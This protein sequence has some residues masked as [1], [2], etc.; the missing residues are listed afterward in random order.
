MRLQTCKAS[1][2]LETQLLGKEEMDSGEKQPLA[3]VR[4]VSLAKERNGTEKCRH[5]R[6]SYKKLELRWLQGPTLVPPGKSIPG[7]ATERA[8]PAC[9]EKE[10][11]ARKRKAR[12]QRWRQRGD[13]LTESQGSGQ[14]PLPAV[15][16]AQP[17][18][19][20][21]KASSSSRS[22]ERWSIEHLIQG[23]K[24]CRVLQRP[25]EPLPWAPD[26]GLIQEFLHG[27]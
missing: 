27:P 3:V 8:S 22:G 11:K 23:G 20:P 18:K 21:S 10:R 1:L 24:D 4:D 6:R 19:A 12:P 13:L 16:E 17:P 2:E 25:Q 15:P 9:R 7:E 14:Q 5:Y 26:E